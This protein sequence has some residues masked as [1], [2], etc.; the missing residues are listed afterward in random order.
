MT[1]GEILFFNPLNTNPK[2]VVYVKWNVSS[3]LLV[4]NVQWFEKNSLVINDEMQESEDQR[5]LNHLKSL[6]L[7]LSGFVM[8]TLTLIVWGF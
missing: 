5:S 7:E 1:E 3:F 2:W 8:M 6:D 4:S